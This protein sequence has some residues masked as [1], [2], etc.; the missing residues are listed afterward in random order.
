MI[1]LMNKNFLIGYLECQNYVRL[2]EIKLHP[3]VRIIEGE[4]R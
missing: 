4:E 3:W 1:I 2:R